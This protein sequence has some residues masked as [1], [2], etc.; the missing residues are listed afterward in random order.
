VA[1]AASQ[2]GSAVKSEALKLTGRAQEPYVTRKEK[3][4]ANATAFEEKV[5]AIFVLVQH[6]QS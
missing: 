5:V 1:L 6:R 3:I 4:A 2:L